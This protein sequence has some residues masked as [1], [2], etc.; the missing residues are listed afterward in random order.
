MSLAEGFLFTKVH[1]TLNTLLSTSLCDPFICSL[2]LE[3]AACCR[4]M[5]GDEEIGFCTYTELLTNTLSN[6]HIGVMVFECEAGT[7]TVTYNQAIGG[8]C[9]ASPN[10]VL[11]GSSRYYNWHEYGSNS[12]STA[13]ST[14]SSSPSS[15]YLNDPDETDTVYVDLRGMQCGGDA[16]TYLC[17]QYVR[18]YSSLLWHVLLTEF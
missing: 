13:S 11:S 16:Y 17:T 8:K 6:Q 3:P 15:T 14:P 7:A 1:D 5:I 4:V 9:W 10:T 12:W 2:T 18:P